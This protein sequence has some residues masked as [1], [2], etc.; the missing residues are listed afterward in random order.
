M[1]SLSETLSLFASNELNAMKFA[2]GDQVLI[3]ISLPVRCQVDR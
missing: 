1:K 2:K 3:L